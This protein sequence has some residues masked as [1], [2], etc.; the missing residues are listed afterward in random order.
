MIFYGKQDV[1]DADIAA[2]E[3][4]LRSDFLTQGPAIERFERRVAAY[5]GAKYA[6]AVTN[7][8]SALH[9]ACRAAGLAE[10]DMLWTSPI[11]FTASA[12]C[13]RYCG[14]DVDFVDI[15]DATYNMDADVLEQKLAAA[16]A[17]GR[18]GRLP[19]V[20]VPVHLAGQSCDMVRIHALAEE[21]GFTVLEDASHATGADYLGGKVGSCAY[22][23]MAV[24]SFH[25][26]KIITTG[27]GGMVLT[28]RADLY[29][30]LKLYRSHGI[31]RDPQLMTHASDG[32]WYYQQVD[33]GYN[34]RMTDI[35]AALGYS[36]MDR[37]DQ[38]V[39]RRR[40]L[41]ARYNELLRDLP[42]RTPHVMDGAGPSWHIYI[43]RLDLTKVKKPKT[44]IFAEMRAR[45]IT[46]NLHY[47]PVH[48][49]PYYE[50]LGHRPEECPVAMQYYKE[51]FTLPL[52]TLLTEEQQDGIVAALKEVLA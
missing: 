36:Q 8:T 45:G 27:E 10:G 35:Q 13:G 49:Q 33:L 19:K 32:P 37:L 52:Y 31:T 47:I 42:L 25:P 15:D 39:A 12:N 3:A 11:T 28:N 51:A 46:L 50:A 40:H 23:D 6:V 26:V 5:C 2:V 14:A 34:Y 38:F 4:V 44:Q 43:V 17:A 29:E 22:S 30:K 18:S 20:V 16:R 41:V 21:Y 24:F 48:T 1:N 7:A 9:I